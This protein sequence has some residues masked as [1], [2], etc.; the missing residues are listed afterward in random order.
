MVASFGVRAP[1]R[2]LDI[3]DLVQD[4]GV[5]IFLTNSWLLTQDSLGRDGSVDGG[6]A[7]INCVFTEALLVRFPSSFLGSIIAR[8]RRYQVFRELLGRDQITSI[9]FLNYALARL[10]KDIIAVAGA[11]SD[12][13][14]RIDCQFVACLHGTGLVEDIS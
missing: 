9:V 3:I 5:I 7:T 12:V 10:L 11:A 6:R 8:P 14:L 2:R 13:L 1:R 4:T